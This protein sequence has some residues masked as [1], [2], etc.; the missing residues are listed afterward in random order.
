VR[1]A[2]FAALSLVLH[3][4]ACGGTST[5]KDPAAGAAGAVGGSAG[6]DAGPSDGGACPDPVSEV[7]DT[8]AFEPPP[9]GAFGSFQ[10]TLSNRCTKTVWPAWGSAGGL[11]NSVIDTQV[12]FPLSPG[13]ERTVTVYGGLRDLGFWG[14]TSCSFDQNGGGTCQTGD[15]SGFVCPTDVNGFPTNA[16]VFVLK[17]G[18]LGGYNLGLRVA[19]TACGNHECIAHAGNCGA[20]SAVKDACGTIVACSDICSDSTLECC[21]GSGSR[22]DS[23]EFGRD[24]S[25]SGDLTITFCP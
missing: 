19:G 6:A 2:P 4:V 24:A 13:S 15:C 8:A 21:S 23:D 22:C 7:P 14:R 25:S 10:V 20:A 17:Q 1:I 12:W 18:F 16:T 3:A 9:L 11:D 5:R